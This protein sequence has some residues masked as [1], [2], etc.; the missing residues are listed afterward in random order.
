MG[1][2]VTG[3]RSGWEGMTYID[4]SRSRD[5]LIFRSDD[6]ER[7]QGHY[8]MPLNKLNT[9]AIDRQGGTILQSTRTN[10]ANMRVDDLPPHL[11]A[12][13]TNHAA[14]DRVEGEGGV[15]YVVLKV[16]RSPLPNDGRRCV[17]L[18][19]SQGVNQ[20]DEPPLQR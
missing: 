10:P 2:R 4:R 11:K 3:L 5:D 13:A 18:E 1:I 17:Y 19:L 16:G 7:W 9:R 12:Y 8:L 6:P 15:D 14:G 20:A